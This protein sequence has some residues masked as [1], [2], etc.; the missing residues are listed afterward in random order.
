MDQEP[1]RQWLLKDWKIFVKLTLEQL[2]TLVNWLIMKKKK[3]VMKF[4]FCDNNNLKC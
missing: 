2:A 1:G 4:N 3:K